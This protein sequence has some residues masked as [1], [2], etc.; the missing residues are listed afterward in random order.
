MKRAIVAGVL[1]CAAGQ[2]CGQYC[3]DVDLVH[4]GALNVFDLLALLQMWTVQDLTADF[5][6]DGIVS[7]LDLGYQIAHFNEHV[8]GCLPLPINDQTGYLEVVDVTDEVDPDPGYGA[9]DVYLRFYEPDSILLNVYDANVACDKGACFIG[10]PFGSYL[11]IGADPH[12]NPDPN[13]DMEAFEGGMSLGENAGWWAL[14]IDNP[15]RGLAGNDPKFRVQIARFIIADGAHV[16]GKISFLTHRQK[17][18]D[19]AWM[20]LDLQAPVNDCFADFNYDGELNI[21]DFVAYQNAFVAGDYDAD[22]D[23]CG[24]LNILDFV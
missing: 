16:D 23:G 8:D 3:E 24:S 11:T 17:F 19:L 20:C 7:G 18:G 12:F 21:L 13:Y 5:T 9:F 1:A 4:D 6:G 22:C 10:P 14:P 2:A 15:P